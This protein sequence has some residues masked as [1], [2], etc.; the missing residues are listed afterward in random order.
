MWRMPQLSDFSGPGPCVF[1]FGMEFKWVHA[2]A[3]PGRVKRVMV[4][5]MMMV[6]HKK[7]GDMTP[8]PVFG[9]Y[10]ALSCARLPA[11]GLSLRL[12]RP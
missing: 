3:V 4:N 7:N 1:G 11:H 9:G 10:C 5:R 12:R 6:L 2:L 8:P